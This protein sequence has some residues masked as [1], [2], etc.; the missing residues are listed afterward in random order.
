MKFVFFVP[1]RNRLTFLEQCV[2]SLL[3]QKKSEW[4]AFLLD[5]C[6]D[7]I[8]SPP[9]DDRILIHRNESRIGGLMNLHLGITR[10]SLDSDDIVCIVDGDDYL[11]REDALDVVGKTYEEKKCLLCYGQ[12]ET[13]YGVG[14]CRPYSRGEFANLR[15]RGFIASHLKS[16]RY[17]LYEELMR[18]D[19]EC[20][21]YKDSF[22][23]FFDASWD[24]A[25]MTPMLEVAGYERTAFNPHVIYHYRQHPGNEHNENPSHQLECCR[26]I[27]EGISFVH[28]KKKETKE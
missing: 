2:S 13:E 12:Y 28:S 17:S 25:L 23:N 16:F 21:R 26:K 18:L 4:R 11:T 15:G 22:G 14:H 3:S 7:D 10:A 8:F 27:L 24:V 19:P 5:D 9:N 20:I 1:F 6:S